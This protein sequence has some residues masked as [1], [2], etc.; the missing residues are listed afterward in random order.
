MK[1]RLYFCFYAFLMVLCLFSGCSVDDS[2]PSEAANEIRFNA[3]VW[4]VMEGTRATTYGAGDVDGSFKVYAYY[5]NTPD[6]YISG[7]I[8]NYS[9]GASSWVNRQYWPRDKR[10]LDFFAYMPTNLASTY[11]SFDPEPYNAE[12]NSDGYSVGNPRIVC[13]NLPM[14][15]NSASPTDGQGSCLQ[16]F[17]YAIQS[18]QSE[19]FNGTGVELTFRRPFARITIQLSSSQEDIHINSIT[20]KGIKNNGICSFDGSTSTWTP[21]GDAT[22]F[23]ATLNADYVANNGIGT[24]I[25]IPQAWA[26]EIEVSAD[27]SVWG[28]LGTHTVTTTVPTSWQAGYNYTYTFTITETD[29]KVDTSKFTEQW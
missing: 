6:I 26:G 18:G 14:T 24:F 5:N 3:D 29:L 17:V 8:V 27:W 16:E 20:F 2:T 15:Y 12:T 22:N 7:E 13:T 21:S 9:G 19:A 25:M 23:V 28:V 4:R 10:S 11:C 1:V